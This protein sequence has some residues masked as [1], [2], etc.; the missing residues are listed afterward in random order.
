MNVG[1]VERIGSVAA[2]AAL[3]YFV[4]ARRRHVPA[5][6]LGRWTRRQLVRVARQTGIGLTVRGLVGYCPVNTLIGRDS[7][8]T[9][10]KTALGGPRGIHLLES[11]VVPVSPAAAYRFWRD[12]SNLPRFMR[13]LERVDVVDS[14]HSHWVA[15]APAGMQVAWDAK[16]INDVENKVIGWKSLDCA[17]VVSAGSVQFR[18]TAGGTQITVHLQYDPPGGKLGGWIADAVGHSPAQ[19]MREDLRRLK[20]TLASTEPVP[21]T[22]TSA[23]LTRP[24]PQMQT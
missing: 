4:G 12:L 21:A 9:D 22:F 23:A 17:D 3:L 2:G 14:A 6:R 24:V 5:S 15:A 11:V 8:S 18:P 13:H 20:T 1:T 16:I 7:H 10:T 19:T